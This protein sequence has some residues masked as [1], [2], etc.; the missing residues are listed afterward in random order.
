V[1]RELLHRRYSN[2][3]IIDAAGLL[4]KH[5]ISFRT[6]NIIGFPSETQ[7]EM[8]D[9][10]GINLQIRPDYPWCSI[11]TPYPETILAE[12]SIAEGYLDKNFSYDNVPTSFFNDTILMRIDRNFILNLHSFFQLAVLMPVLMPFLRLLMR[13]PPNALYRMLFKVVYSYTSLRSEKRSL[14][15]FLKLALANRRLFK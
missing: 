3:Q 5:G 14:L 15:S 8:L 11:F 10:L 2:K 4:K 9:T 6:Y 1:R 7:E 13:F 12:Y